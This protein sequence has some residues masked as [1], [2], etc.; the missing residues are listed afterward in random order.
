MNPFQI[1]SLNWFDIALIAVFIVLFFAFVKEFKIT[2]KRS[3]VVLLGLTALGGLF[4]F[5]R[6][7]RNQLLKQFK[8]RE[9][10][11]KEQER[12]YD[13]LRKKGEITEE[14]YNS[15]KEELENTLKKEALAIIDAYEKAD[16]R[17]KAIKERFSNNISSKDLYSELD[18]ITNKDRGAI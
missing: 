14:A 6:W 8:E 13:E 1:F 10:T 9:E 5:Q 4:S 17:R 7:R 12:K 18:K 15:A 16:E 11:L 2:S 3:W